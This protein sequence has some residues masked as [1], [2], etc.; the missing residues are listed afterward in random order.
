MRRRDARTPGAGRTTGSGASTPRRAGSR[1]S[2]PS[3]SSSRF[4]REIECGVVPPG[5]SIPGQNLT[6]KSTTPTID[7][8]ICRPHSI[9]IARIASTRRTRMSRSPILVLSPLVLALALAGCGTMPTRQLIADVVP[10]RE[11]L[12]TACPAPPSDAVQDPT[13]PGKARL[14]QPPVVDFVGDAIRIRDSP[15]QDP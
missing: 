11:S 7:W 9:R 5:E 3:P 10:L 15:E 1:P 2:R 14:H 8:M 6:G 4:A 12:L 13:E